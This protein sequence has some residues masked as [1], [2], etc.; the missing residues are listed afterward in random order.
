MSLLAPPKLSLN[1]SKN[2]ASKSRRLK[3]SSLANTLIK[4]FDLFCDLEMRSVQK[5]SLKVLH[6]NYMEGPW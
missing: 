3:D 2:W 6:T 4:I 5:Y 1:E